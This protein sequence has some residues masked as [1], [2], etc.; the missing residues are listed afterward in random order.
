MSVATNN[1][2]R[3][4]DNV[5]EGL[6]SVV[7]PCYKS[8]RTLAELCQRIKDMFDEWEKPYEIILVNDASPDDTWSV[9]CD[10]AEHNEHIRG[11][12]LTRNFGQQAAVLCGFSQARGEFVVTID[13]D[14]Q[15]PPEEIPNLHRELVEQNVDVVIAKLR[16]KTHGAFRNLGTWVVR[17]FSSYVFRIPRDFHFSAFR[18]LRS[19]TARNTLHF[20]NATPVV[21][22]LILMATQ[23]VANCTIEHVARSS[24]PSNYN[25]KKLVAY[26]LTMVFGYSTIPLYAASFFGVLLMLASTLGCVG[27][28]AINRFDPAISAWGTPLLGGAFLAG[29]PLALLGLVAPYIMRLMKTRHGQPMFLIRETVGASS[30]K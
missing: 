3:G 6:F 23:R 12:N 14:L 17:Q 1:L 13:D 30:G 10:L 9:I 18:V 8:T 2:Q 11:I 20:S 29:V 7:A 5:V 24:G 28:L 16:G 15:H 22:F 26:F 25:I 27:M 19:Q 21:G 4:A